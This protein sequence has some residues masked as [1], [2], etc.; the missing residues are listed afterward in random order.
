MISPDLKTFK[1]MSR[2][3]NLIAVTET[4][5]ADLETPVSSFLKIAGRE[6]N[7]FLLESA[8]QEERVGRYSILGIHPETLLGAGADGKLFEEVD[9]K[10]KALN[11]KGALCDAV[12]ARM[13]QMKLANPQDLK[14]FSGGFVG[15]L[16]YENVADFDD[17]RL[18]PLASIGV[19]QGIFVFCRDLVIFDHFRKQLHFVSLV[20]VSK[21]Q[22]AEKAYRRGVASIQSLTARLS[23]PLNSS[24]RSLSAKAPKPHFHMKPE[25]FEAKVKRVKEYIRAG[26]CIQVVLSQRFSLPF[27]GQDFQIYRALRSINPSPYMFYFRCGDLRL[28]GSSPELLVKKTG[29]L[30]EVRPIAGT[31]PRGASIREDLKHEENLKKSRKEL[32]EHLMLV[33]LG[34]NDLGRVC[35]YDSIRVENFA[36]VERYSHVM[37]L[38][39]DVSGKLKP[40]MTSFD[41][42][43]A[44]FPAGTVSGAPKIRAMEI[45]NEL[46]AE[47]RGPYA[48]CLGYFGLN[49]DMDMCITIRTMVLHGGRLY[50]QAGAGIVK[51]SNPKSEYQ[52]T[53]NKAKALFKA[54]EEQG[55]F[56]CFS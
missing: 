50:L 9:G 34:R 40:G 26:D 8:E 15:Y 53:V 23:R 47:T 3:G 46:E 19:P 6:K 13:K 56:K 39:S 18:K 42:L 33:D 38:V 43:K 29:L 1:Q 32:A 41:L 25:A 54:I 10:R 22:S 45:I 2:K 12:E 48:G 36:R 21:S 17:V 4:V 35:R 30:A 11:F 20:P 44:T 27:K 24:S 7:A 14:G 31:R 37:H 16:S 52:E 49:G 51:D 55:R 5:P 28:I